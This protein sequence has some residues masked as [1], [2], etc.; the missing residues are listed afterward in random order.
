MNTIINNNKVSINGVDVSE[1]VT[2]KQLGLN[3]MQETVRKFMVACGQAVFRR[4]LRGNHPDSSPRTLAPN[5]TTDLYMKLVTEEYG[6][7]LAAYK[8]QDTVGIA[9]GIG[10]LVWVALA[11]ANA[12]G[13]NMQPVWDEIT[14]SNMSK[15]VD[16]KV[17]RREGDGKILKPDTYFPPNVA[18]ALG[19]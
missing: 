6:E 1:L 12:A 7:L 19:I 14:A 10:D 16:G 17:I 8:D 18:R 3:T 4:P 15:T 9:D 11:L 5:E 13:I 2:H